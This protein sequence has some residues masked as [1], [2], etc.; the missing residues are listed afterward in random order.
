MVGRMDGRL[1]IG[2]YSLVFVY[3]FGRLL[4]VDFWD[5]VDRKRTVRW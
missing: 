2:F 5:V 3:A 1:Q 4:C